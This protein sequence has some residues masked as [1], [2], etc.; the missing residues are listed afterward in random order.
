[1]IGSRTGAKKDPDFL[2]G[3]SGA[4]Q[5][6]RQASRPLCRRRGSGGFGGYEE[7]EIGRTVARDE[8]WTMND[9]ACAEQCSRSILKRRKGKH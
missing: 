1:M 5:D 3:F 8:G 6:R 2:D 7:W 9:V 4:G